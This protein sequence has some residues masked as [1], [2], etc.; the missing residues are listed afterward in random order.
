MGKPA[1]VGD[2]DH[3]CILAS[4]PVCVYSVLVMDS[5]CASCWEP[6]RTTLQSAQRYQ[7]A[8]SQHLHPLCTHWLILAT[9]S[10]HS[11]HSDFHLTIY[12]AAECEGSRYFHSKASCCRNPCP[13]CCRRC[14]ALRHSEASSQGTGTVLDYCLVL[15]WHRGVYISG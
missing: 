3:L 12:P 13:R 2:C 15:A 4:A 10:Q 9:L 11:L 14:E 6:A 8:K 5:R 7:S 1:S